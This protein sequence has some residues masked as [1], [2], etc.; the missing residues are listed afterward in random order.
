MNDVS[1]SRALGWASIGIGLTE[2]AAT[3]WLQEQLGVDDHDTLLKAL[4]AR[5]I[6]SGVT[7]LSQRQPSPTLTAGLWS[8]VAGDAMDLA[9]LGAAATESRN[10]TG[11][12]TA[13]AMVLGV[14]GLDVLFA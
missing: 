13:I 12:G 9:L 8:R 10:P 11:L 4:G 6:A 14:T 3:D 7:I 2:I 1:A 5:E